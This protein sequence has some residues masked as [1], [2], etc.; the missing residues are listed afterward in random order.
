MFIPLTDSNP[1]RYLRYPYV[2]YTL[3]AL[4]LSIFIFLQSGLVLPENDAFVR[5]FGI[6]PAV[7]AGAVPADPHFA[8]L[9]RSVT[10]LT[11]MFLHGGWLHLIGNMLFL[12]TF[13][14]NIEDDLG[15]ARYL[16]FYLLCGVAGGVTH[17]VVM[18]T[19]A[20]PLIGAS[21]AVAG[22]VAAYLLLHPRIRIWVLFLGRIPLRIT[23]AWA[24]GSWVVLQFVSAF[25]LA[26]DDVAWWAHVG[27][28]VTGAVLVLVLRRPGVVLFDR[29]QPG[30]EGTAR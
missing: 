27:G 6:T 17:V 22:I 29:A 7:L 8:V 11:Y 30:S 4:N 13:G 9:P 26:G 20:A 23:A 24:L 2:N 28:I 18:P 21:G 14:D 1:L 10:L 3:V 12:W 19:S 15:H 25:A 5:A 16:L